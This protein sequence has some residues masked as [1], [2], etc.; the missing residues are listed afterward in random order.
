MRI[1]MNMLI[2]LRVE[3]RP[4]IFDP[5]SNGEKY[6]KFTTGGWSFKCLLKDYLGP[7]SVIAIV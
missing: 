1:C 2:A 6:L 5:L 4:K 7:S 3:G